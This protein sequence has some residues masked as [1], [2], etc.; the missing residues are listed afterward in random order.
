M[1]RRIALITTTILLLSGTAALVGF[2]Q[3]EE[4]NIRYKALDIDVQEI[5]GM[6]FVDASGV[7]DA[8]FKHDSIRGSFC[9]DLK[10]TEVADW[11]RTIPAVNE[12]EVY[13]GLDRILHIRISQRKPIARLHTGADFADIYIDSEGKPLEL[14]PYFTARVPVIHASNVEH[15]QP[16]V[17]FIQAIRH[18]PFWAAFCDQSPS[19]KEERLK[20][21]PALAMRALLWTTQR[22]CN[23]NST[24]S[25][26]FTT[27]K[28][29]VGT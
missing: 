17:D 26:P 4:Q 14:S 20:S 8:I 11:V 10:L 27:S 2:A 16:A 24:N 15:A 21:Y 12:V 22:S 5:D 1:I 25:S 13:P 23:A 7:R 28:F 18:D 29:A 6:F 9:A 19:N 3:L